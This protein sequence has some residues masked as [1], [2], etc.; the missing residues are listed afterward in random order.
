M[1]EPLVTPSAPVVPV[2]VVAAKS[3]P[4]YRP[5]MLKV[6]AGEPDSVAGPRR[7]ARRLDV[8][9]LQIEKG[10]LYPA[11]S[12]RDYLLNVKGYTSKQYS[13][14][15]EWAPVAVWDERRTK[16]QNAVTAE[17]LKRHVDVAAQ[18]QDLFLNVT[19]LGI[20]RILEMLTKWSVEIY[21]E[22]VEVPDPATP[23]KT[24]RVRKTSLRSIDVVNCMSAMK[25]AQDIYRKAMGLHDEADSIAG[26]IEQMRSLTGEANVTF[27]QQINVF[28]GTSKLAPEAR[29]NIQELPYD[30]IL[31]LIEAKRELRRAVPPKES[32]LGEVIIHVGAAEE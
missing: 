32:S 6:P 1:T 20:T 30:D 13:K 9:A 17:L 21:P 25:H 14:F 29:K 27:N 31:P 8:E 11:M 23:G 10:V 4:R 3:T 5:K 15:M 26:V 2:V 22:Y 24:K 28:T 18:T 19:R 16:L 7:V 12:V